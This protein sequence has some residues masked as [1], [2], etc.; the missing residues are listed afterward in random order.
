MLKSHCGDFQP[1][2]SDHLKM[3]KRIIPHSFKNTI[4]RALDCLTWDQW[5]NRSWSQEGEDMVLR[6]IFEN[7]KTGIYIDVGAHHPKR[8]SNT[9]LFYQ[10]G[11]QGINI[12]A[13][14][15]SM[16]LFNKWRPRDINLEMGVAQAT[17]T[18][19]YYIFNEKALNGFSTDLSRERDHASNSYSINEVIRVDVYPLSEI[20]DKHLIHKNIDFLT[21][22]VE[23]LDL[24][25]LKSNDWSKYRPSYV[26]A[27][28]L[29]CSLHD[30]EHDML[31]RFM[32]NAGYNIY[33]KQV[34][35][36]FFK[37]ASD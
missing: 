29:K 36:V 13:M 14:P 33:A 16:Q 27:E 32:K 35:T 15:G 22:D 17:G 20:L 8:F 9:Y 26:L 18:L 23:G 1:T 5:V 12:D 2:S 24:D 37:D 6:R 10:L 7:K 4:N 31:V 11:W 25:V 3:I 30:L 28:V 34:N 19:D 21:V